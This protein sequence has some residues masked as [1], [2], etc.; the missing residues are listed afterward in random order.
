MQVAAPPAVHL[1]PTALLTN[2][3]LPH[4]TWRTAR[5]TFFLKYKQKDEW[6]VVDSIKN[7]WPFSGNWI[8]RKVWSTGLLFVRGSCLRGFVSRSTV[9]KL[10]EFDQSRLTN[11]RVVNCK[12]KNTMIASR[13]FDFLIGRANVVKGCFH[14][15]EKIALLRN[16][17]TTNARL[18]SIFKSVF[19]YFPLPRRRKRCYSEPVATFRNCP[20]SPDLCHG[21]TKRQPQP[22]LDLQL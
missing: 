19:Q 10:H 21:Q 1:P 22:T 4:T 18:T 7:F 2:L 3:L 5:K 13:S 14:I 9:A 6:N 8:N 16:H 15:K 11:S 20:V 17:P 12:F